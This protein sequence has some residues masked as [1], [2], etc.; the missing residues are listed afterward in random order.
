MKE[1][2]NLKSSRHSQVQPVHR[3][4]TRRAKKGMWISE[5]FHSLSHR[6]FIFIFYYYFV[7]FKIIFSLFR[8]KTSELC[9]S[10]LCIMYMLSGHSAAQ[11]ITH[12]WRITS[13]FIGP[14]ILN[15]ERKLSLSP[16]T[17]SD[18]VSPCKISLGGPG[19][20]DRRMSDTFPTEKVNSSSGS[21]ELKKTKK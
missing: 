16:G 18:L 9:L 4:G 15:F 20:T 5:G 12:L 1:V 2:E 7:V 3:S 8:T 17:Q 14:Q 13:G 10:L 21:G 6:R 11:E 19:N